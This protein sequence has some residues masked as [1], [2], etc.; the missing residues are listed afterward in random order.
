[1]NATRGRNQVLHQWAA[2][3]AAAALAAVGHCREGVEVACC[4]CLLIDCSQTAADT[5]ASR[6]TSEVVQV[7]L[8]WVVD[9]GSRVSVVALQACYPEAAEARILE[10]VFLA[11]KPK[12]GPCRA[13][14][15]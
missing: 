11:A 1:M 3:E 7:H 15:W 9:Q 8:M 6:A 13:L 4:Y 10:C 2:Q 14:P 5:T 12:P